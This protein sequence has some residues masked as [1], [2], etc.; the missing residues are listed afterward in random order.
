MAV[1]LA[2]KRV[3]IVEDEYF[4]ATDLARAL[5]KEDAIV[6]GPAGNI[7]VAMTLAADAPIDAAVLDINLHGATSYPIADQL[8]ERAVPCLFLTG[9]D[10][11]QVPQGYRDLPRVAK[12]FPMQRVLNA[13]AQLLTKEQQ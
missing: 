11:R 5:Q 7:S 9:Y 12:P 1:G 6:V 13:V 3:L 8:A 10:D 4:I 2:G